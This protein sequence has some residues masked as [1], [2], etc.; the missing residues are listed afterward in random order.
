VPT[1]PE[2]N[3]LGTTKIKMTGQNDSSSGNS[4]TDFIEKRR[5][6]L[7]RFLN[8]VAKHPALKQDPDFRDFLE[9]ES[10]LPRSTSTSALSGAGVVRLF[11]KFGETVNK[12]SF[13]MDETDPVSTFS[14]LYF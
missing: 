5:A 3:M 12:I 7:E 1:A 11:T 8:R 9:I 14:F 6:E 4:S 10:D 13:R 2:K